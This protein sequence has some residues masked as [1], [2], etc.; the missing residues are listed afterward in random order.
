VKVGSIAPVT[1]RADGVR[2]EIQ[3]ASSDPQLA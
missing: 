1:V 2:S 3:A